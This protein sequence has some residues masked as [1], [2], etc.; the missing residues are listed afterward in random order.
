MKSTSLL[1]AL[2]VLCPTLAWSAPPVH[3]VWSTQSTFVLEPGGAYYPISASA[4]F[5]WKED[6]ASAFVNA[7]ATIASGEQYEF[8]LVSVSG[9]PSA[10]EIQGVWNV[11]KNGAPLCK[12]CTGKAYGLNQAAGGYNYFKIYV[13]G[14]RFHFGGYISSRYDY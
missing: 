3:S 1:L 11:T 9:I 5:S 4:T 7:R 10:S 12:M 13:D 8:Q 2:S 14:E 6:S